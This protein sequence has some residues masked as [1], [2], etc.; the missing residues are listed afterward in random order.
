M[1]FFLS[2]LINFYVDTD[3]KV[4]DMFKAKAKD[5]SVV[6]FSQNAAGD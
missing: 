1:M 4:A 5:N 2:L 6:S 3:D